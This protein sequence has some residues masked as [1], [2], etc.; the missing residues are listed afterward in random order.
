MTTPLAPHAAPAAEQVRRAAA[1]RAQTD[2]EFHFW[3]AFGWTLLTLGVYS[4]YIF[5]QLFRR[6]RDHN[7][8]RAALLGS[9]TEVGWDRAVKQ[10]KADELRPTFEQLTADVERLR[11]MDGEFRDPTVWTLLS[12]IGGGIVWV[13]GLILL[14]QD[15]VRHERCERAAE[16]GLT[17][18]F[19]ALGLPLPAPVPSDKQPHNYVGRVIATIVTFGLYSLWWTADVMREG[20]ANYAEDDAWEDA[21]VTAVADDEAAT[22]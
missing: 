10:G 18:V 3:T 2:Y 22:H 8:R 1:D 19:G 14:D 5:Y 11:A 9:A 15:L 21:L 16:A 7:R 13:I 12:V 6:S 17:R 20:N 4:F